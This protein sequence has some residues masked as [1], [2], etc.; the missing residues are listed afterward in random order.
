MKVLGCPK[1]KI[2]KDENGEN[3]P[4]LEIAEVLLVHCKIVNNNYQQHLRFLYTFAPSKLFGQLSDISDKNSIFLKNFD[5]E[6]LY[7]EVWFIDQYSKLPE[8][9][10]KISTNLTIN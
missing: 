8:I 1:S 2:T 5:L 7:I 3:I 10:D 6:C 9:K 4:R